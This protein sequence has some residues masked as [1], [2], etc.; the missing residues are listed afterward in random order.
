MTVA[1]KIQENAKNSNI[2]EVQSFSKNLPPQFDGD[3]MLQKGDKIVMPTT[4]PKI[5]SQIFGTNSAEFMVVELIKADGSRTAFNFFPSSLS[6]TIFPAEM[7]NGVAKLKLP[8]MHPKGDVC[9]HYLSFRGK[10]DGDK[11]E[12]QQ[13]IESMLG[14]TIEI[15]GDDV[16]KTQKWANGVA[17]NELK[18]THVFTYTKK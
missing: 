17:L 18:D 5:Y 16:V 12:V 1:E 13:A 10:K 15:T 11:S 2:T 3:S 7:V 8:V 14:W 9:N 4:M 6:K